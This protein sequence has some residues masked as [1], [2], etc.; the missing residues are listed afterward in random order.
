MVTSQVAYSHERLTC[1][2]VYW[3]C[4][5]LNIKKIVNDKVTTIKYIM[6][7]VE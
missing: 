5:I 3:V 6:Y 7:L 1:K 2:H 4:P